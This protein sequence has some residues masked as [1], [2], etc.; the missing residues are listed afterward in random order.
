MFSRNNDK[1]IYFEYNIEKLKINKQ[2]SYPENYKNNNIN[3]WLK[4]SK[5]IIYK[6]FNKLLINLTITNEFD[7]TNELCDNIINSKEL[8]IDYNTKYTFINTLINCLNNKEIY[9]KSIELL[10]S[11]IKIIDNIEILKIFEFQL[12]WSYEKLE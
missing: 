8:I 7:L 6:N 2:I 11:T 4:I 1:N 9:N 3:I 5:N 10:K 12:G